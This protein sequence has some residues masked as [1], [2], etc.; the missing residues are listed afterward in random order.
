MMNAAI[1]NRDFEMNM[2]ELEAIAGGTFFP[3][4]YSYKTYNSFGITTRYHWFTPDEF[5]F[6]GEKISI[7]TADKIVDMGEGMLAILNQGYNH[8]DKITTK[9]PAFIR[10]FN[11]QLKAIDPSLRMWNGTKGADLPW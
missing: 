3:N 1:R 9:E 7:D 11:S 8:K 2:E 5:Y 10:A 6:G 4:T